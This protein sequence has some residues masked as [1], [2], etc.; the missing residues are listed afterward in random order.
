MAALSAGS[1]LGCE[2]FATR[3]PETPE[4]GGNG[5]WSFPR[6][7]EQVVTNVEDAVGRRSSVDWMRSL[8]SSD[9]GLDSFVFV[10]DPSAA[11]DHP[12]L[13]D[14]WGWEREMTF[15]QALFSDATL[16][17]DSISQ[18]EITPEPVTTVG[19][20]AWFRGQY[21][22]HLGH[23]RDPAPRQMSGQWEWIL[24]RG[25]DGGWYVDIWKDFRGGIEPC[26]SDLKA[27]F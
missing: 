27:Q 5:G 13:F 21:Q 25:S 7:P 16:P 20:T 14:N 22:I 15:T 4:G 10:A 24:R 8:T 6:A 9:A 12:A 3:N 26:W 17:L 23:R 1:L 18:L 19:D 11:A 2:L